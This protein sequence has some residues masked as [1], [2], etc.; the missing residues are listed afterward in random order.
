MGTGVSRFDIP[1]LFT[2][3][4][5][6]HTDT[7]EN[8]YDVYFKTKMVDLGEVGIPFF[9]K[10][11][12]PVLYPKTAYALCARLGIQ[13]SKTSGKGVW[14]MFD[15]RDFDGIRNRTEAEVLTAMSIASKIIQRISRVKST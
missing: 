9:D 14:E 4:V 13:T 12:E 7:M 15:A 10:N 6:S 1:M 11:Q 8:L 2:R 5:I 3:S